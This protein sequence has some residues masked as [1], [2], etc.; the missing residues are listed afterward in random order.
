MLLGLICNTVSIYGDVFLPIVDFYLLE[1]VFICHLL[2]NNKCIQRAK[3]GQKISRERD[4]FFFTSSI[5][6]VGDFVY[7]CIFFL[8]CH[9]TILDFKISH[10]NINIHVDFRLVYCCYCCFFYSVTFYTFRIMQIVIS[11][12]M[13]TSTK[14]D[15][16]R[17]IK[18]KN[19][20]T[21]WHISHIAA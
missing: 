15:K 12:T 21:P 1:N 18:N 4:D 9:C 2:T 7:R 3:E 13:S 10:W 14:F 6:W 20:D 8:L 16:L 11:T 5:E 19:L 17:N